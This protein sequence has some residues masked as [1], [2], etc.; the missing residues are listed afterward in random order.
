MH[1]ARAEATARDY[2]GDAVTA[3]ELGWLRQISLAA[4]ELSRR[5]YRTTAPPPTGSLL[6][7]LSIFRQIRHA[8][9]DPSSTVVFEIGPGSG[10]CGALAVL[11]G[12]G[13]VATDIAQGFYLYQS[14][15]LRT[16]LG[17]SFIE[18]CGDAGRNFESVE[19]PRPGEAIHVP[20]WQFYGV[21][22]QPALRV[23]VITAN[24]MLAEMH[25]SAQRF[26]ARQAALLLRRE[27][28]AVLFEGWGS[29]VHTPIWMIC[30]VFADHGFAI[31]HNDIHAS[32]F[33]P[34]DGAMAEGA[35]RLG[36]QSTGPAAGGGPAAGAPAIPSWR[37]P[38]SRLRALLRIRLA[39]L[40]DLPQA[41]PASPAATQ[42]EAIYHPP[43]YAAERSPLSAA[44]ATGREAL[45]H[46]L[47][48]PIDRVWAMWSEISG[49]PRERLETPDERF[50]RYIKSHYI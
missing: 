38:R 6:R 7:A 28:G 45:K 29:T 37:R 26:L 43:I 32:V 22:P 11:A 3:E 35:L 30:K 20:W 33:V 48:V 15:L 12:Y 47:T 23:D 5:H 16:L 9:P 14:H 13:Y 39:R 4:I 2:L 27:R 10:Y 34:G 21:A 17:E 49:L 19:R 36:V 50:L 25:P 46:Q 42:G 41:A 40:L 31:A 8:Y 24:H 1:E 44:I 18:L